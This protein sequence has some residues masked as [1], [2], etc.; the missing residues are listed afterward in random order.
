MDLL[1]WDRVKLSWKDANFC[2][3]QLFQLCYEEECCLVMENVT[4]CVFALNHRLHA[5]P[6]AA[7]RH[8]NF[9]NSLQ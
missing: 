1:G 6:S 7:E 3:A 2:F 9:G 5:D 8:A 4:V